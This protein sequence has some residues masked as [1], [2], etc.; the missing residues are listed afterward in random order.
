[1]YTRLWK[2]DNITTGFVFAVNS[3]YIVNM[4]TNTVTHGD[5]NFWV[6]PY[7]ILVPDEIDSIVARDG[8]NTLYR[9][10]SETKMYVDSPP[11][12]AEY[13]NLYAT[14]GSHGIWYYNIVPQSELG[15]TVDDL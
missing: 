1:M 15:G 4:P 3:C 9:D 2:N 5:L 14:K 7:G 12:E 8:G 10:S 13:K 11:T 6:G